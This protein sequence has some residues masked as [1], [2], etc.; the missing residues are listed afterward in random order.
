MAD[1]EQRNDM[2]VATGMAVRALARIDEQDGE[3]RVRRTR[4]HVARV[5]LVTWRIRHHERAPARGGITIGDI[6]GDAL[7]ALGFQSVD[8]QGVVDL[9]IRPVFARIALERRHL[10]LEHE[11]LLEEQPPDEGRLA[12]I[13]ECRM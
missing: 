11:L 12:V 1:A 13:D 8:E 10:V 5:L 2:G 4:H 3:L 9:L 7:L 6:D